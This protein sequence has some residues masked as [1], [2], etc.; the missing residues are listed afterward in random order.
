MPPRI[1][2]VD[3]DLAIRVALVGALDGGQVDVASASSGE[4]ALALIDELGAPDVVLTDLRMGGL[5][6]IDLLRVISD[7]APESRVVIMTAY[8]DVGTAVTAMREGAADFL[9]KPF[10]LAAVRDVLDRLLDGSPSGTGPR[11]EAVRGSGGSSTLTNPRTPRMLAS[12]YEIEEEVGRGAMARV[13]RARDTRHD[14]PVA[15]KILRAEVAVSIGTERFL[16][17]I[18]IAARLHHPHILTLI[19]SGESDGT[20]FFVM[21]LVDGASLRRRLESSRPLS[22]PRG[23][24]LLRDVSDALAAAHSVGV[25]HRDVKPENVLLSGPHAWVADFGVARALWDASGARDTSIGSAI[26]TP[27]YMAPEQGTGEGHVDHRADIYAVGVLAHEVLTGAPPFSRPSA[28]AI[29]TAHLV[30]EPPALSARRPEVP[31]ELDR[32]VARCLAK[33]PEERW[34]DAS[35]LANRFGAFAVEA[36]R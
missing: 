36:V 2:I 12:R 3:D 11:P 21:P 4:E 25:V 14:R 18:Q 10:D 17:E 26:G 32:T 31:G 8:H 34:S 27:Q 5:D 28:R 30:D 23:A 16:R 33:R 13:F 6:G 24:A 20:P 19:D 9:C 7:R 35:E 1:L 22:I 29:L 15:V